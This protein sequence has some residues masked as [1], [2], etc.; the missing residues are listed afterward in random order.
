MHHHHHHQE[1][2]IKLRLISRHYCGTLMA[3]STQSIRKLLTYVQKYKDVKFNR[4]K[5]EVYIT[6]KTGIHEQSY[7]NSLA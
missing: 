3:L 1:N 6:R 2:N 5:D 4:N 7:S